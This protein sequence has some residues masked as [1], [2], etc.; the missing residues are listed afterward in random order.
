MKAGTIALLF[1]FLPFIPFMPKL[2]KVE[3]LFDDNLSSIHDVNS[4]LEERE[5]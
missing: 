2:A 4:F 5:G 1:P 3:S